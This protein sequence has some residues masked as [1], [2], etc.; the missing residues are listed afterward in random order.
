VVDAL[1]LLQVFLAATVALGYFVVAGAVVPRLQLDQSNPRFARAVRLGAFV[2][3][4]GCGL[5]H[6][7]ILVHAIEGQAEAVEVH[8]VLFHV[9]QVGGVWVFALAA[10]RVL[11]VRIERRKTDA[12][13]L[14][15]RIE[16]LAKE[17]ADLEEF[18]H[19]VS[20][21]LKEPLATIRGFADLLAR[22]HAEQLGPV[23]SDKVEHIRGSA[24]RMQAMLQAVLQYSKAA[25]GGMQRRPVD[26]RWLVQRTTSELSERIGAAGAV[27]EV[28]GDLPQVFADEIQLG[29]VLQNLIANAVKFR[30]EGLTPVVRISAHEQHD[31]SIRVEVADNGLG[32]APEDRERVF[33]MFARR[34]GETRDGT[35]IGLAVCH[36]VITRHGGRI[37]VD[38]N[39]EGGSTFRFTLP[40]RTSGDREL[41]PA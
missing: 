26:L 11:D 28:E 4:V 22:Q 16:V 3:F 41:V 33:G 20:H 31:G 14:Q 32:I 27:V 23:G 10:L 18:A 40:Q 19:A 6:T 39:T 30:R 24:D 1:Q 9:A 7:H 35:G 34:R 36:K 2:F 21:D 25:G 12:E 13:L 38:G 15:E 29:R 37:W 8:E 17:N 5:T